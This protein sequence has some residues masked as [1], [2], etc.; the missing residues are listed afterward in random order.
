MFFFSFLITIAYASVLI[1][2]KH[3]R[4]ALCLPLLHKATFAHHNSPCTE[5]DHSQADLCANYLSG[6]ARA[7]MQGICSGGQTAFGRTTVNLFWVCITIVM[8]NGFDFS[9]SWNIHWGNCCGRWPTTIKAILF[10][11]F[12]CFWEVVYLT[13]IVWTICIII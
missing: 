5:R 3:N 13:Y 8:G 4:C 10:L 9:G 7:E 2:Q 11:F 1:I 12:Y 6:C